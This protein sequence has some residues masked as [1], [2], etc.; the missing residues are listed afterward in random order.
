P[1]E[2]KIEDVLQV[3]INESAGITYETGLKA[4]LRHDPDIILIGELRDELTAQF[5]IQAALTGHLALS[6][7][8]AKNAKGTIDRLIDLGIRRVELQQ[9]LIAI[10]ASQLLSVQMR[11]VTRRRAA[12]LETL[13]G[14]DLARTITGERVLQE[15]SDTSFNFLRK[16]A[17]L[18]GFITLES[19]TQF[20]DEKKNS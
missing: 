4:A 2:K 16:K 9:T 11:G 12:I 5:A 19:F 1:V 13:S 17:Y 20:F 6:T 15:K 10:A 14:T 7:L 18:Y 3:E 8:H